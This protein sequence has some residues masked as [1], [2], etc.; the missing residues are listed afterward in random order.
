[1][2]DFK[3]KCWIKNVVFC[4]YAHGQERMYHSYIVSLIIDALQ[5]QQ[6][7]IVLL[8]LIV[9]YEIINDNNKQVHSYTGTQQR[10]RIRNTRSDTTIV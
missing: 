9:A 4:A 7:L 2:I 8:V 5:L 1:M 6:Y 10:L 3:T